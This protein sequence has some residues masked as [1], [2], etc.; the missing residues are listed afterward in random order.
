MDP[1]EWIPALDLSGITRVNVIDHLGNN[2]EYR[3]VV[4]DLLLQDDGR[5]LKVLIFE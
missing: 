2:T 1:A 4:V 3:N 5:T